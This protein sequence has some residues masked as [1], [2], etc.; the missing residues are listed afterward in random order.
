MNAKIYVLAL[1]A[2]MINNVDLQAQKNN[3]KKILVAYYSYSGNTKVIAEQIKNATGG[4][5]FEIQ[6]VREYPKAY[7]AVVDQAKREINT[8]FK[9][10]LKSKVKDLDAYDVIFIGSPN[11][12]NTFAPPVTT[13]LTSYDFAGKTIVPFITHEGSRMGSSASDVRKL[14]PKS[15]VL[16]GLP[17]RGSVVKN[18]QPEVNKWLREIKL[19]K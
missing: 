19:L 4:D 2:F 5:I 11:W 14:C 13:F 15:T 10:E 1:M 18:A 8:N 17:I 3:T 7:N 16:D 6:T 9:P 12:W